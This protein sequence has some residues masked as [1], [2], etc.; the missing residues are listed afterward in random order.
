LASWIKRYSQDEGK[1]WRVMVENKYRIVRPNIFCS[2]DVVISHFWKGV[3]WAI[4]AVKMGY[5]W[6]IGN[7]NMFWEDTWCGS[8]PLSV[9]Y[10][11]L[12]VICNEHG[13][14]VA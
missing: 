2:E 14:I 9:Q 3:L 13:K 5:K 12:Y 11:D 1:L 7:G 6:K 10:F 4:N 8:S